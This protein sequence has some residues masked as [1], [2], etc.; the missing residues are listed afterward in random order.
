MKKTLSVLLAAVLT[1]SMVFTPITVSAADVNEENI[2]KN[3]SGVTQDVTVDENNNTFNEN[4]VQWNDHVYQ[5]FDEAIDWHAA[6]EKCE[7]LGGHLVT[8]TSKEENDFIVEQ[9]SKGSSLY[10]WLGATDEEVEGTWKWVTEEEWDYT[11]WREGQPDN[12]KKYE[13]YLM[14]YQENRL[15]GLWND[16][17]VACTEQVYKNKH[18]FICEWDCEMDVEDKFTGFNSIIFHANTLIGD[19][20][21]ANSIKNTLAEEVPSN[22]MI[23]ALQKNG[24]SDA[25][26]VSESIDIIFK[27]ADEISSIAEYVFK[28]EDLY[29]AV[30]LDMLEFQVEEKWGSFDISKKI[31]QSAKELLGIVKE[32]AKI[33]LAMKMNTHSLSKSEKNIICDEVTKEMEKIYPELMKLDDFSSFVDNCFEVEETIESFLEEICRCI[34]LINLNESTKG[35]VHKMYDFC[36]EENRPLRKALKECI[37]I[38]DKNSNEMNQLIVNRTIV[39]AGKTTLKYVIDKMWEEIRDEVM[40]KHPGAARIMMGYKCGTF[41]SN[42]LFST[43]EIKGKYIEMLAL[44]DIESLMD[45]VLHD[46]EG[47]YSDSHTEADALQLLE[48]Y[49]ISYSL[50]KM[51]CDSVLGYIDVLD[52]TL[53]SKIMSLW[54]QSSTGNAKEYIKIKKNNYIESYVS[55]KSGWINYLPEE[56]Y[57]RYR[58]YYEEMANRMIKYYLVVACPVDIFIYNNNNQLVGKVENNIPWVKEN[59]EIGIG[60]ENDIKTVYFLNDDEYQ[61]EYKGTGKGKMRVTVDKYSNE[62]RIERMVVFNNIPLYDG[63]QYTQKITDKDLNRICEKNTNELV[64]ANEDSA[65]QGEKYVATIISGRFTKDDTVSCEMKANAGEVI[66]IEAVVP[67]GYTFARW[68]SNCG[69]SIFQDCNAKATQIE[70]PGNDVII[71]AVLKEGALNTGTNIIPSRTIELFANTSQGGTISP[72]GKVS[73]PSDASQTFTI[74]PDDGYE[75][76][77]VLVDGKNI[78][79]V[80]SYTFEKVTTDHTISATFKKK[81]SVNPTDDPNGITAKIKAAKSV[82][83]KASSSQ[84]KN[85]KGKRYI[86]VKW[87]KKGAKVSGYQVYRSEKK[88]SGYKKFFTTKKKYYYNTKLLKKGKRY[89]YK[90]R[91]YTVINGKKYYSGWSNLAYRTVKKG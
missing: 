65:E 48:A 35:L 40:V 14:M 72:S 81:E 70:M 90:V 51:D 91:A 55:E 1:V 3:Q 5:L 11:N 44:N 25:V 45:V 89:Y 23:K 43:D 75:V 73:V 87:T 4:T 85:K 12:T 28:A 20:T 47:I 74:T 77:E 17:N 68:E 16:E 42:Q 64:M 78:G 54:G 79:A 31:Y 19:S 26:A 33:D 50:R 67:E 6:K 76:A 82:K 24:F 69:N 60:V 80:T 63:L 7:S 57:Q 83:I 66:R 61:V 34:L 2:T 8:I 13:H 58:S 49:D 27:T 21:Y 52:K 86:K 62:N 37:E 71:R 18:G 9:I 22:E 38:I 30:I 15:R 32:S 36:P 29:T 56:L 46:T 39:T 53:V 59:A 88:K 84:G 10:Y 41:V